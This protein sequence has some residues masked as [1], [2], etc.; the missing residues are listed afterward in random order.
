MFGGCFLQQPAKD[1]LFLNKRE[2]P[3]KNH[4]ESCKQSQDNNANTGK[5]LGMRKVS[6]KDKIAEQ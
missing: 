3:T 5:L 4:P 2:G 6:E 1:D